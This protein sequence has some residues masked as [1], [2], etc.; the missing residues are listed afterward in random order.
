MGLVSFVSFMSFLGPICFL[1]FLSLCIF[2]PLQKRM[3][4]CGRNSYITVIWGQVSPIKEGNPF[5]WIWSWFKRGHEQVSWGWCARQHSRWATVSKVMGLL[6]WKCSDCLN[7]CVQEES[8]IY[9]VQVNAI[10][11]G[12]V[13]SLWEGSSIHNED[14]FNW[15]AC[16]SSHFSASWLVFIICL[17]P[18]L[19]FNLFSLSFFLS[20]LLHP[21]LP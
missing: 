3:P 14:V 19:N 7:F 18:T 12:V 21:Y 2:L 9:N 5:I 6:Y 20:L 4:Q 13:Y 16:T 8:N 10:F 11:L 1:N 15:S 17:Y